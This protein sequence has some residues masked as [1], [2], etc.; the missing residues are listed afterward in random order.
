M[1]IQDPRDTEEGAK[2]G[3]L[4]LHQP[5]PESGE[6]R[7]A[8]T[9]VEIA[10][11]C[12]RHAITIIG[13]PDRPQSGISSNGRYGDWFI[14]LPYWAC[15]QFADNFSLV[16]V[17]SGDGSTVHLNVDV[18]RACAQSQKQPLTASRA[19]YWTRL[20]RTSS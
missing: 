17:P 9:T 16:E 13:Q 18:R 19:P 4:V 20:P 12:R 14:Y 1:Y 6:E 15:T 5:F 11:T 10:A 2:K 3:M 8:I 7:V